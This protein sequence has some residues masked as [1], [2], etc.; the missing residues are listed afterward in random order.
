VVGPSIRLQ[1]VLP[2]VHEFGI[3]I[4]GGACTGYCSVRVGSRSSW[5]AVILL[6]RIHR[7]LF[8]MPSSY[9]GMRERRWPD[10]SM[11]DCKNSPQPRL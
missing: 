3:G 5:L 9:E 4:G 2:A 6:P 8:V 10:L 11:E 7:A 1:D